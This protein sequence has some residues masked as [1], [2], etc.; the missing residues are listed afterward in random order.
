MSNSL[1]AFFVFLF[2]LVFGGGG[3]L[4]LDGADLGGSYP[5]TAYVTVDTF[6]YWDAH[7]PGFADYCD[8]ISA[9]SVTVS[10]FVT[11]TAKSI[12]QTGVPKCL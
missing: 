6:G 3:Y 8:S 5:R 9:T 2:V 1:K 7:F 11:L 12:D 4:Y 10:Q